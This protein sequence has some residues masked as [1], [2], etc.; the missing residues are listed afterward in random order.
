MKSILQCFPVLHAS[1]ILARSFV[2]VNVNQILNLIGLKPLI[3]I[4]M[5]LIFRSVVAHV[6]LI[7]LFVQSHILLC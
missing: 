1:S 3:H 4:C 6:Y 5:S 7:V 2:C